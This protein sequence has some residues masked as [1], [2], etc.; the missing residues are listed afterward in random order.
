M[1]I[2]LSYIRVPVSLISSDQ[3]ARLQWQGHHF[4]NITFTINF[5]RSKGGPGWTIHDPTSHT[6]VAVPAWGPFITGVRSKSRSSELN[7]ILWCSLRTSCNSQLSLPVTARSPKEWRPLINTYSFM[8][9]LT[10]QTSRTVYSWLLIGS[11]L[12]ERMWIN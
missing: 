10:N 12:Q 2:P 3:L 9:T 7:V 5:F 6:L 8:K 1:Q 11:N 4:V